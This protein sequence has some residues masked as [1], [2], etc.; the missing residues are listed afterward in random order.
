MATTPHW[1]PF[2]GPADAAQRLG[3][4]ADTHLGPEVG[5]AW[6]GLDGLTPLRRPN[7]D[8]SGVGACLVAQWNPS[9][10]PLPVKPQGVWQEIKAAIKSALATYGEAQMAQSEMAMAQG[11]AMS[12]MMKA[13]FGGDR[14]KD[15]AGAVLDAVA[16]GVAILAGLTG[17]GLVAEVAFGAGV[18]LLLMDGTA[19]GLEV[20]GHEDWASTMN[21]YDEPARVLATLLSLPDAAWGGFKAIKE[22]REVKAVRAGALRVA[23]RSEAEAT[24]VASSATAARAERYAAIGERANKLAAAKAEKLKRT[25][26]LDIA[27]RAGLPPPSIALLLDSEIE[28][29]D[30]GPVA[31]YLRHY[32][33]HVT[34]VTKEGT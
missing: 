33:F 4:L 12:A 21:K 11:Q 27:P 28:S 5:L 18:A 19:Y 29:K 30:P 8:R 13:A 34:A 22:L 25:W 32:V 15:A 26:A 10:P 6:Y 14:G 3:V 9:P 1:G 24:R 2:A 31:A 23:A 20:S 7:F 16:V 17:V